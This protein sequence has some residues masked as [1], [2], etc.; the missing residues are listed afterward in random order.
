MT[1]EP[2]ESLSEDE[3]DFVADL[4]AL[5]DEAWM[6]L[7]L[8]HGAWL[9]QA[10]RRDMNRKYQHLFDVDDVLQATFM[11]ACERVSLIKY[12]NSKRFRSYL[13]RIA[14]SQV[15]DR[16]RHY[17]RRRRDIDAEVHG[18]GA[19]NTPAMRPG[20]RSPS[21]VSSRK[22]TREGLFAALSGLPAEDRKI[23]WDSTIEGLTLKQIATDCGC[24]IDAARHRLH[25]ALS[26]LGQRVSKYA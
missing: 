4:R 16:I 8:R 6:I 9:R 5:K 21:S 23:V 10:V 25:R 18:V 3:R 17:H 13:H 7:H 20:D 2:N 15:Q 1:P 26:L 19:D 24:T 12:H 14:K 22:E 11:K